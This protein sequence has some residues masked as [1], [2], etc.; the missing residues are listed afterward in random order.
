M[1]KQSRFTTNT[2]NSYSIPLTDSSSADYTQ[3]K[4]TG[5]SSTS[6]NRSIIWVLFVALILA[7]IAL[8]VYYTVDNTQ[9]NNDNSDR[10]AKLEALSAL[11]TAPST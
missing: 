11:L 1:S 2:D 5:S 8:G 7:T 3:Q 10:I 4:D 6:L 9:K